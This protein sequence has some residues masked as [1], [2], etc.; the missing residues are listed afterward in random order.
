MFNRHFSK[1][2]LLPIFLAFALAGS[3]LAPTPGASAV[4]FIAITWR[5]FSA[6]RSMPN[7]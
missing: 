1:K 2:D 5:I 6:G 4:R 3:F 7:T